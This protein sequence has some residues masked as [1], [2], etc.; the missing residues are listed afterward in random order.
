MLQRFDQLNKWLNLGRPK[1]YWMTGFFNPQG[2]L[3]AMKQEV[4]RKHSADKWALDDVVMT[5]EVSREPGQAQARDTGKT[6]QGAAVTPTSVS[7]V[8]T[9]VCAAYQDVPVCCIHLAWNPA[10]H[11]S[12]DALY[13]P[14]LPPP[15]PGAPR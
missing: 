12:K 1:A 13:I 3:T 6:T 8:H 14:A 7:A 4:S 9:Q 11:H 2:F 5:S 15:A 10:G